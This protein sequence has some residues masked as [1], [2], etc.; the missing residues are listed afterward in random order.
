MK[1]KRLL[2]RTLNPGNGW[3]RIFFFGIGVKGESCEVF[4]KDM[5]GNSNVGNKEK[6]F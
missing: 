3:E 5:F 6:T 1:G 2:S 4:L